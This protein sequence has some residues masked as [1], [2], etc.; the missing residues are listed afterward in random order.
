M[1]RIGGN[2]S[3]LLCKSRHSEAA[4]RRLKGRR[5]GGELWKFSSF[6]QK[7]A[8]TPQKPFSQSESCNPTLFQP[9]SRLPSKY[10]RTSLGMMESGSAVCI[11]TTY[12]N[13]ILRYR[14]KRRPAY[15]NSLVFNRNGHERIRNKTIEILRSRENLIIGVII[16]AKNHGRLP[17][18]TIV[19]ALTD[20]DYHR[21]K[22][23]AV[24]QIHPFR[25]D[26]IARY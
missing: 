4:A 13:A 14:R 15:L 22:P 12:V 21:T 26:E 24:L 6:V 3:Q 18:N 20:I 11:F 8:A 16:L 2:N 9:R 23:Q 17:K 10:L 7:S 1:C 5:V 19:A 25:F